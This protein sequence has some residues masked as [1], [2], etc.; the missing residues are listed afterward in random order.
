MLKFY[1]SN[2]LWLF[3]WIY[4]VN[5]LY[6]WICKK[7]L[8]YDILKINFFSVG[9]FECWCLLFLVDY[10]FVVFIFVGVL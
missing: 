2:D 4:K 8:F 5:I 7:Y 9:F 6:L 10:K 3:D 1:L